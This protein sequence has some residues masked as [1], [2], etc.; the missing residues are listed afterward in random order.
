MRLPLSYDATIERADFLR[1]LPLATGGGFRE[2]G[3]WLVG[4]GWRIRLSPLPVLAIASV[5]MVR[6]RV[7]IDL[8]GL[9]PSRREAFMHRFT[10]TYQRGGG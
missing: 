6:H 8:D 3:G 7:E 2:E 4:E 5:R 1:L 10:L 9:D